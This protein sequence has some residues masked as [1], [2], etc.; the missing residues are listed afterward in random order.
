MNTLTIS[1]LAI[2]YPGHTVVR[3]LSA[4]LRGGGLTCLVGRNGTGKSTLLRTLAAF[5]PPLAGRVTISPPIPPEGGRS[6]HGGNPSPPLRGGGGGALDLLSLPRRATARLISVVLTRRPDVRQLTAREV[7]ALGRSPYT[8][9]W[10][11][12]S[13][14]D[15]T[16]VEAALRA[17][18][19]EGL[20]LRPLATLSDGE[21]QKVMVAKAVAQETPVILLD[22]PT[23]FLDYPSKSDT[24]RLLRS[25]ARQGTAVLLSTHDLDLALRLA[26]NLW[27]LT[28]QGQLVAGPPAALAPLLEQ[29]LDCHV[30]SA[31]GRE[32]QNI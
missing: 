29:E 4:T 22:E 14:H 31:N 24:L 16:V 6:A 10:G 13:A 11:R 18:G 30:L 3:G 15:E 20:A 1:D 2:G 7:V 21:C 23:A 19:I 32:P 5:Q 25:L 9:L 12:L 17:T 8:G 28:R 27:L 26:D